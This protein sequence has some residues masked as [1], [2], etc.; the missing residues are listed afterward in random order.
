[1]HFNKIKKQ[2]AW[3]EEGN[4]AK[5]LQANVRIPFAKECSV[6]GDLS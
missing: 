3:V 1:M 4:F 6:S 5:E 2:D